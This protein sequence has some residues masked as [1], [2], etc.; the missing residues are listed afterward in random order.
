[1][2]KWEKEFEERIRKKLS[3]APVDFD[4]G[5]WEKMERRL[6]PVAA[7]GAWTSLRW[8]RVAAAVIL[9]AAAGIWGYTAYMGVGKG[10]GSNAPLSSAEDRRPPVT[11]PVP[12]DRQ[13]EF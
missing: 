6:Y 1:M 13:P 10:S 4:P 3:G 9:L 11:S 12:A 5:A 2:D 7:K 8:L